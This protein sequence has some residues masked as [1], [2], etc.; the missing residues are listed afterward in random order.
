MEENE[1]IDDEIN[2]YDNK[3]IDVGSKLNVTVNY[4]GEKIEI[5]TGCD[6]LVVIDKGFGPLIANAIRVH[7]DYDSVSWIVE[8]KRIVYTIKSVTK[9]EHGTTIV[10]NDI[11]AEWDEVAKID[12][13]IEPDGWEEMMN[14]EAP[15]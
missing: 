4:I 12:A 5:D 1:M 8:R 3:D 13:N 15:K 6:T 2:V 10:D 14:C 11:T 9:D 7:L